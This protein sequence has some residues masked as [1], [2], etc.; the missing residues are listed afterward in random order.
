MEYQFPNRGIAINKRQNSLH[1]MVINAR[2]FLNCKFIL[3]V[4]HM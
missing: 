4:H 2:S 3:I 1:K